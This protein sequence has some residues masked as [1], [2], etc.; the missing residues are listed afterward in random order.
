[1][2]IETGKVLRGGRPVTGTVQVQLH[3]SNYP[4]PNDWSGAFTLPE[5]T[6]AELGRAKL[7]LADGRAGDVMLYRLDAGVERTIVVNFWGV[8]PLR[9]AS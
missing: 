4:T 6:P 9:K 3:T 8:G 7:V 1:V 5:G 2:K